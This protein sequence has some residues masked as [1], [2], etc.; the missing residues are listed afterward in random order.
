M[1]PESKDP[2]YYVWLPNYPKTEFPTGQA[3]LLHIGQD[4]HKEDGYASAGAFICITIKCGG[5]AKGGQMFE[6]IHKT[7]KGKEKDQNEINRKIT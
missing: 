1:Q 7:C 6:D 5:T 4:W 3:L 2:T